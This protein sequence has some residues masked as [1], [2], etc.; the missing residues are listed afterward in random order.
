[1]FVFSDSTTVPSS[2]PGAAESHGTKPKGLTLHVGTLNSAV[3][4][5]GLAFLPSVHQVLGQGRGTQEADT[6]LPSSREVSEDT[7]PC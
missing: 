1:M 4:H 5:D 7:T 3:S 2:F 6:A